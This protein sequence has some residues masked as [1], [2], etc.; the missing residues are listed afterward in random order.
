MK[1]TNKLLTIVLIIVTAFGTSSFT[2]NDTVKQETSQTDTPTSGPLYNEIAHMDS[3][4]FD[5]F[6]SRNIASLKQFFDHGLE[7]YQDNIGVRNYNE[8]IEAFTNL[9]KMEYVLTRKLVPGSMEVYP[10]KG[11]GAIQTG[12]HVFSHIENGKYQ[13][14]TF[15]FMQIWQ[16]K[17]G[18]WQVTTEIT[19]GH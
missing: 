14:G 3:L 2:A 6:N 16:K 11:Y 17:E 19:Y 9:F 1:T 15:K 4:M 13:K 8:T 5:A 18:I 10:I 7:L 12:E